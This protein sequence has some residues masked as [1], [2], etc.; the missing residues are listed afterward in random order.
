MSVIIKDT[1]L[2][3]PTE[4]KTINFDLPKD[5]DNILEHKIDFIINH[6]EFLADHIIKNKISSLLSKF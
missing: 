1:K 5:V 6:Y 2:V 4:P 3:I